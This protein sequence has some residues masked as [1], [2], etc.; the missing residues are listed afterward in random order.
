MPERSI[1]EPQSMK[2]GITSREVLSVA[3]HGIER[4]AGSDGRN[5][6]RNSN[7]NR[8]KKTDRQNAEKNANYHY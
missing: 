3:G 1:R 5:T 2:K 4:E 8:Q 6:E 7:G